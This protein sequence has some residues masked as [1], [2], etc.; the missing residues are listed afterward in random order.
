MFLITL[1]SCKNSEKRKDANVIS[2]IDE[3]EKIIQIE[4]SPDQLQ[5]KKIEKDKDI[6][7]SVGFSQEG[8]ISY[9]GN[10][11]NGKAEGLWTTFFPDG[12]P[13][14]QGIKKQGI[15]D[16]P[17]TLW[18]ENGRKKLTGTYLKGKKHGPTI[19]WYP[20]GSKWQQKF[21]KEGNPTGKWKTWD[22]NGNIISEVSYP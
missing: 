16:G 4:K 10:F 15:N 5:F 18:Y 11:K 19:A 3:N 22:E 1:I 14:W 7:S 6:V 12:K 13:R 20:N 21:F 17:F 2:E 9:E 8:H